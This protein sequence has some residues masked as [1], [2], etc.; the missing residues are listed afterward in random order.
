VAVAAHLAGDES[1]PGHLRAALRGA[2]SAGYDVL[3]TD[4]TRVAMEMNIGVPKS[5]DAKPIIISSVI[6]PELS[7]DESGSDLSGVSFNQCLIEQLFINGEP[8]AAQLPLFTECSLGSV[9]GRLGMTDLPAAVFNDC[10]VDEFPDGVDRNASILNAESLPL[11][12][13]VTMTLLRKLYLQRGS[14]RKESA[15]GRGMAQDE[16]GLVK[17]ALRLLQREGLAFYSK[18]GRSVV[19]MPDRSAGPRVRAYL[20]APRV[21]D[22]PLIKAARELSSR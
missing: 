1:N 10:N 14:G 22:D 3:A 16:A 12:T 6:I 4:L 15:L 11:G 8:Q 18:Q 7:L 20:E 13:R 9:F 19:W 5:S 17:E 2:M 21:G